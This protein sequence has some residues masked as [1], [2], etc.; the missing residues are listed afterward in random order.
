[1]SEPQTLRSKFILNPLA[2]KPTDG[3]ALARLVAHSVVDQPNRFDVSIEFAEIY[4]GAAAVMDEDGPRSHAMTADVM[5][6][7]PELTRG[8]TVEQAE[9]LIGTFET[10]E[11]FKESTLTAEA[12]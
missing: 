9:A 2:P 1:M 12:F 11:A 5:D 3:T 10:G 7:A 8:L 6:L 4:H